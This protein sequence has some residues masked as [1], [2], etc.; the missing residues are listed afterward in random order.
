MPL[1]RDEHHIAKMPPVQ[2]AV[3]PAGAFIDLTQEP[4]QPRETHA[5]Q[6]LRT[7]EEL[8][9]L[10]GYCKGLQRKYEER[11]RVGVETTSNEKRN[12]S[13]AELVVLRGKHERLST[14][15][16]K[17]QDEVHHEGR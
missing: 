14:L 16:T 15:Y 12:H 10:K 6:N 8:E 17:L 3:M 13:E 4:D 2:V 1:V 9:K 5:D 11:C 7:R